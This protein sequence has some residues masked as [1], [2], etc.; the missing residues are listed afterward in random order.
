MSGLWQG[1]V[2]GSVT[3]ALPAFFPQTAY[4]QLK[5]ISGAESDYV[6]RLVAEFGADIGAAHAVLGA[7]A[8]SARL[9]QV[10]VPGQYGH[11]IP[12]GVCDNRVGYYEVANSRLVYVEDGQ[13]RS[14]GI[15]S[16][17][18]WRGVWYVVHFGAIL[19]SS[20]QGVVN[21]PEIGPGFSA[22]S[23]TC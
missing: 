16:L 19:R 12:S 22:D 17:I 20:A 8:S 5:T 10:E 15:A 13:T 14:L 7:D 11:W 3:P 1:V 21:D 6:D 4:L 9:V 2:S 18:S 23:T